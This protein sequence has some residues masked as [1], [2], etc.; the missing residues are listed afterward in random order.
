MAADEFRKVLVRA[1]AGVTGE[2]FL[3]GLIGARAHFRKYIAAVGANPT[4]FFRFRCNRRR[5]SFVFLGKTANG[6]LEKE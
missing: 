6:S 1:V 5:V 2:Q 3:V 4:K